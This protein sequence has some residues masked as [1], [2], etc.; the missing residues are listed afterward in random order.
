VTIERARAQLN[1]VAVRLQREYPATN[2]NLWFNV[3]PL[4]KSYAMTDSKANRALMLMLGAVGLVL[5]IACANVANLL[6]ARAVT[7][8]RE[9][10]VR[11]ALGAGRARLV[12]Q[13]LVESVL[14]FLLGG[15]AGILLARVTVDSLLGLAVSGGYVPER[16]SVAVDARVFLFTFI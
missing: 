7:R 11:A 10:V 15:A 14:L 2:K 8:S 4:D 3:A 13:T 9:Y 12:R 16:M 1:A 5:L 6:L